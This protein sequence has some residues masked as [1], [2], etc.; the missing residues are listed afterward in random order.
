MSVLDGWVL[1]EHTA[2]GITHTTYRKG[3]GPGV[4]V[5]SEIPGI[6]DDVV[7]FAEEVVG[8]G[9]TVVLPH[10]FG[11]VPSPESPTAMI[12]SLRQACVNREFNKLR[13]RQTSPIA[14][15]LRSVARELHAEL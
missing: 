13:L 12:G 15:W 10:L 14:D 7:A 8:Q 3:S 9:F 2:S 4:V 5:I 6:T 1:G 11:R